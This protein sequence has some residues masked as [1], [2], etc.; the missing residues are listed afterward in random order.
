[1]ALNNLIN[2]PFPTIVAK[3]G[4]GLATL[5]AHSLQ[6]GNGTGNMVQLGVAANGQLPIG[7]VGADPVLATLTAGTGINITNG[8]GSITID[9]TITGFSTVNQTAPAITM[10]VNT[11]YINTSAA[12]AK[13]TY[14]LP[15][16]AA[17]GAL[18]R[19]IGT[20]GNS[21]GWLLQA[22]A[23]QT[24]FVGNVASSIAGTVDFA[25]RTD[26]ITLV[27]TV[28]NTTFVAT[29]GVTAGFDIL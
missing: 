16:I 27:C 28:A 11:Q 12:N 26:V 25:D 21:G 15:A 14:T 2:S 6:V 1:M 23:G 5:T 13:V 24:V 22:A 10:A 3:G 8:A 9:S 20:F 17:Q 4:T 29:D 19:I 18:F 7:S